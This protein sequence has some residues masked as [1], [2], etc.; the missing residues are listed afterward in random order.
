MKQVPE[1]IV[2][3]FGNIQE[4]TIDFCVGRSVKSAQELKKSG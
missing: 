2:N 1:D 4:R 3:L